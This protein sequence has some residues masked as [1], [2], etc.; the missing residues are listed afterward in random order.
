VA[1]STKKDGKICLFLHTCCAPCSSAVL[2]RLV[3]NYK[4]TLFFYNPNI[5]PAEEYEKRL[6]EQRR[7]ASMLGVKLIEG[8]YDHE[9]FL[10]AVAGLES[11]Q[12]GNSRCEK[13]I[14]LRLSKTAEAAKARGFDI[15]TTTLSVSPHKNAELINKILSELS[16]GAL[17]EDFKKNDGFKRSIE[18]SK[19]YGLYRQKYCGC[20]FEK[21]A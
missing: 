16:E 10:N 21:N 3:E 1:Y 2:E 18:L 7:L 11:E 14:Q 12:E 8:D 4:V 9:A 15:F 6:S 5:M 17:L 13:C 19:E 20:I